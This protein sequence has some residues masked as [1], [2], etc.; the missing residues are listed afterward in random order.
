MFY[1]K[2]GPIAGRNPIWVQ[3]ML[4]TLVWMFERFGLY[5]NLGNNKAMTCTPIFIWGHLVQ[6]TYKIQ[7][8][9]EGT[10]FW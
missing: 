8:M 6:Y 10:T 2:D 5:K 4:L 1:A 7:A 9:G 3:G